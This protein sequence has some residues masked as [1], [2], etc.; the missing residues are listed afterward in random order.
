MNTHSQ[1]FHN[2]IYFINQKIPVY[3]GVNWLKIHQKSKYVNDV[4]SSESDKARSNVQVSDNN[5]WKLR[6]CNIYAIKF[7]SSR[8]RYHE[9]T[10]PIS[11][12]LFTLCPISW[13]NI[14]QLVQNWDNQN[15]QA[16]NFQMR[17]NL[18]ILNN[19]N[20]QI[21]NVSDIMELERYGTSIV[22]T[23]ISNVIA[24]GF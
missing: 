18:S 13:R 17:Y 24:D 23:H 19:Q 1:R 9:A 22:Q 15:Q 8:N 7:C 20:Y 6:F 21:F 11:T 10:A 5:S 12:V 3:R 2:K 4:K 14:M 16:K